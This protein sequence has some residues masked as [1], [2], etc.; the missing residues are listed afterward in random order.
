MHRRKKE[1]LWKSME[2]DRY[3]V[4]K[5]PRTNKISCP[6]HAERMKK[7][8]AD[9]TSFYF[10][11]TKIIDLLPRYEFRKNESHWFDFNTGE[12][13]RPWGPKRK[14]QFEMLEAPFGKEESTSEK[15]DTKKSQ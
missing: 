10:H 5:A 15:N 13:I 3:F 8:T 6:Q 12:M 14:E 1:R 4:K 2:M 7:L 9:E 11:K